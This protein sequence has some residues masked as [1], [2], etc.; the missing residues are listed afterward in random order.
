MLCQNLLTL[1][2]VDEIR[3]SIAPVLLGDGVSLF[4]DSG[5]E[6][7]WQLKDVVAYR[8]GIVELHYAGKSP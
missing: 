8:T 2:L 3:L 5:P 7:F 6:Q 1:G 4:G